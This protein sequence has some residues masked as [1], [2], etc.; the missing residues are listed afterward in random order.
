MLLGLAVAVVATLTL[1]GLR[2]ALSG[3]ASTASSTS[4]PG[5]IARGSLIPPVI[6]TTLDGAPFDLTSLR[7]HPVLVNFW[8]PSCVPCRDEFPLFKDELASHAVDGLTVVGV[9]MYDAPAPARDFVAQYGATW[10]TVDDTS[11]TIRMALAFSRW[12]GSE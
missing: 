4:E 3:P 12:A 1:I 5:L 10:Q 9:L 11:G 7:G 2:S 6:G 8:G